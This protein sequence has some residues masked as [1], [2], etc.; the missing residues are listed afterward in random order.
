[1]SEINLDKT[2]KQKLSEPISIVAHQLKTP[3]SI[4]KF[5]IEALTSESLG[6]L[7]SKQREYLAD[8]LAN[9]HRM[10][11]IV[12]Y[13]LDVSK[14]E[15]NRYVVKSN[16]FDLA[17]L[18]ES[19][20]SDF[21][22]WAEASN[23]EISFYA[24]RNLPM[25]YAD[26]NKIGQVIENLISNAIKYKSGDRGEIVV[27]LD[28][29]DV[30]SLDMRSVELVFSC[31]DNGIG[32]G[33]EDYNK[34]FSKFYRS[35]EAFGIDPSGSGLGLYINRAAVEASGGKIWFESNEDGNGVTFYFTLPI[36]R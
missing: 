32:I 16:P 22:A 14:I 28:M 26:R 6:K 13:L 29:R 8:S 19:V 36:V 23:C 2:Y 33:G 1:M 17:E 11:K 15:G 18:T 34:V 35:E 27:R 5:Y 9:V 12:N 20:V 10:A 31:K 3:I 25:A 7:N 30:V 21:S 24:Q 4:L